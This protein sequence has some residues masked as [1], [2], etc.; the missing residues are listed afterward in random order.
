MITIIFRIIFKIS[1]S[2]ILK[3]IVAGAQKNDF[4]FSFIDI[5]YIHVFWIEIYH[6]IYD[7]E[8]SVISEKN[9]IEDWTAVFSFD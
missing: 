8:Y 7:R 2:L 4:I 1:L 6:L 9:K 5:Y 3:K